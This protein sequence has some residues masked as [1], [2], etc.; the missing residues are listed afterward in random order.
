MRSSPLCIPLFYL[1]KQ[2][3]H[4]EIKQYV[5]TPN[6]ITLRTGHHPT[7]NNLQVEKKDR[8][9]PWQMVPPLLIIAGAFGVTG[10]LLSFTDRVM[11]GRVRTKAIS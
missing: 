7:G 10:V 11:Y 6:F 8:K 9:M 4:N 5:H 2:Y 3:V 1:I